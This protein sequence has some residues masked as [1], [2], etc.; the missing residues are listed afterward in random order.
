MLGE[1]H[2]FLHAFTPARPPWRRDDVVLGCGGSSGDT[3]RAKCEVSACEELVRL[4]LGSRRCALLASGS[5]HCAGSDA[6]TVQEVLD[7]PQLLTG[8]VAIAAGAEHQC[9]LGD[10]GRVRCWGSNLWQG[11]ARSKEELEHSDTPVEIPGPSDVTRLSVRDAFYQMDLNCA[12]KRDGSVW[13][14]GAAGDA[15]SAPTQVRLLQGMSHLTVG[16]GFVCASEAARVAC[17]NFHGKVEKITTLAADV[18]QLDATWGG[19][20]A[21]TTAGDLA[22]DTFKG[23]PAEVVTNLDFDAFQLASTRLETCGLDV[24]G[25]VQCSFLNERPVAKVP[26]LRGALWIQANAQELCGGM[27]DGSIACVA[28]STLRSLP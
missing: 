28:A 2:A 10:D 8:A 24:Q 19:F 11:L 14:W 27:P 23:T 4:T 13:C 7:G 26:A 20:C 15:S 16:D 5:V 17:W 12:Q 3:P 18:A 9:A 6:G 22:C 21:L 1:A 25:E